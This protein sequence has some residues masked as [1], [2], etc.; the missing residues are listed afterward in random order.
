MTMT[1]AALM[2]IGLAGGAGARD[3][4]VSV[5][6]KDSNSGSAGSPFATMQGAQKVV[7]SHIA[8]G[9]KEPV[10][11]IIHGGAYY[12]DAPLALTPEDSGTAECP[13]TWRAAEGEKVVLSGGVRIDGACIHFGTMIGKAFAEAMYE[14]ETK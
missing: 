13:I 10:T 6:G 4:H 5:D 2:L 7:R 12:L 3:L 9:L 8:S 11:V 1:L 14:M